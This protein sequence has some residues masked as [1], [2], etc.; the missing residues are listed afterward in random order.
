MDLT[1]RLTVIRMARSKLRINPKLK[2]H[3][4]FQKLFARWKRQNP[5]ND[6]ES[7]KTRHFNPLQFWR[8]LE[9]AAIE[10]WSI[11]GASLYYRSLG[12]KIPSSETLLN[13][14]H[15]EGDD[16]MEIQLN[17]TLEA[18]F[19][20]LPGKVRRKFRQLGIVI[21]DV[22]ED[23][24]YGKSDN[25]NIRGIRPNRSA[26]LAYCYLTADLYT[27]TGKLTIALVLWRP[28]E[29]LE[30]VFGDLLARIEFI[31]TP[32]L[33]IFD[34]EFTNVRI[35]KL[36]RQKRISFVG[37]LRISYRIRPLALAYSLTDKW[38]KLRQWRAM[39]LR[40][41]DRRS[42]ITVHV[43]FQRVH[44]KIKALVIS[45]DLDWSP[46]EAER[47]YGKRF[48]IESGYRD[49]HQFQARTSSKAL[50][51][52]Y[53]ILLFAY[54]FWNLCQIFFLLVNRG[55]N[56]SLSRIAKWRREF[57]TIKVFLLRDVVL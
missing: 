1:R 51:V 8:P 32:K 52:R 36:L 3:T 6:V 16:K 45:P 28:G 49:K 50:A 31:L 15:L 20:G 38:E 56:K 55:L 46:E 18:F 33:L 47:W 27:P 10:N 34:G 24:Y 11:T 12:M 21:I 40:S 22:H 29:P 2:N 19:Q 9:L 54:I 25:P 57:R 43:T 42:E 23:P 53:L 39:T 7:F 35:M 5:L 4:E 13:C 44:T 48:N 14:C 37:R 41:D 30:A 17:H 26:K